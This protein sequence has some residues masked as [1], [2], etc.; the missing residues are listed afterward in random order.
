MIQH[1][2]AEGLQEV[3]NWKST[4][5]GPV[6][7]RR[8][9]YDALAGALVVPGVRVERDESRIDK[10]ARSADYLGHY[11]GVLLNQLAPAMSPFVRLEV[12]R[13]RVVPHVERTLGSFVHAYLVDRSLLAGYAELRV[14]GPEPARG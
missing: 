5:T 7:K 14:S 8:A 12:G 4:N 6:R 1:G 13:A 2:S 3:T 11:P 9:F 10:H